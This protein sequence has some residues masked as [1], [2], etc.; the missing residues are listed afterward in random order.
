MVSELTFGPWLKRRRS[1]LGLTQAELGRRVGY[2]KG[3][4]R[5]IEADEL[6]PSR[7]LAEK[8]AEELNI[9][10][11][12]RAAFI[13]FARDEA[14]DD[15]ALPT[16]S[17]PLPLTP[18]PKPPTNLPLPRDPLIGRAQ[19]V[20]SV[21]NLLLRPDIA[22]VTL[23]GPGG[24]GKTRLALE[25]AR[26]CLEQNSVAREGHTPLPKPQPPKRHPFPD[27]VYFVNLARIEDPQRVASTIAHALGVQEMGVR[28]LSESLTTFLQD[29]RLL[30]VLDNFEQV[31]AAAP[32][33]ADL[34]Q[35]TPH[36][37]ML[38]TSRET[39]HLRGEH[40]FAVPPL[41]LPSLI[42]DS[43]SQTTDGSA[44]SGHRLSELIM[45]SPAIELFI[46]RAQAIKTDFAV[47]DENATAITEVCARLDGLPLAIELAAARIRLFSPQAM[48]AHLESQLRFLTGGARDLPARQQ[49]MRATLE[50]SYNLL[51]EA[52]RTVLRRLAVFAGGCTLQAA[53]VVCNTD[54]A[55]PDVVTSMESL[56]AKSLLREREGVG[57]EP[58]FHQL[59]VIRE[60]AVERLVASGETETIR[61]EH[62]AYFLALA[63]QSPAKLTGPEQQGWLDR[64]EEEHDNLRAA[65]E[66]YQVAGETD[67]GLRLAAS[68]CLFWYIRGYLSEGRR[69]LDTLLDQRPAM[70]Q[71]TNQPPKLSLA[72]RA[73]ALNASGLLAL[74]QSDFNQAVER[75]EAALA[76]QRELGDKPGMASSLNTLGRV[77]RQQGDIERA[78][79]LHEAALSL[80]REVGDKWG[81]GRASLSL[82]VVAL[83]Q[84]AY[85]QAHP[86]LS[87]SLAL[88]R[89]LGDKWM[90]AFTLD[91]LAAVAIF[92][93]DYPRALALQDECLALRREIRDK[94]GTAAS[95]NDLGLIAYYQGDYDRAGTLYKEALPLCQELGEKW[96]IA[97]VL[98]N[99]GRVAHGQANYSQATTLSTKA[100]MLRRELGDKRGIARSLE[101]L[102]AIAHAQADFKAAA[103]L[104]GAAEQ[105]RRLLGAPLPPSMLTE[106]NTSVAAVRAALREETFVAAWAEGQAMALEQVVAYALEVVATEGA[107]PTRSP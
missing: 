98:D 65:L 96:L 73:N 104:F 2:A 93:G 25:V 44:R 35:A 7:Q 42:E 94:R 76:F 80:W 99:L 83:D 69:W 34:L 32:L 66:W 28:S 90:I 87:E 92:Q 72:W 50:W 79:A 103:R 18:P 85:E 3:T 61:H 39:L 55:L 33:V 88:F 67:M 8:L 10:P 48:L 51:D 56:V 60:Y 91:F 63:E 31:V 100:L 46:A 30:L 12:E 53:D 95:L 45:Q 17:A 19:D 97:V 15:L 105:L 84:G 77:A 20:A 52:E 41:A 74:Q 43:A 59:R 107:L 23:T 57:G 21:Y 62:A 24:V 16:H 9:P 58:R 11:E 68:L 22:L 49:T 27:G 54:A 26:A 13:R 64:L 6:R 102:A 89:D 5:K 40:A 106:Y 4:I 86:F 81:I 47:T 29:R 101:G 75:L 38:V 1:G 36:L 70:S 37:K 71:S 78:T 14:A 82:G